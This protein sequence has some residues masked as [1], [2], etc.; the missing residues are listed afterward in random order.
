MATKEKAIKT[1]NRI[2]Y[3]PETDKLQKGILAASSNTLEHRWEAVNII[4][5]LECSPSWQIPTLL[6][7]HI[8]H[9]FNTT[10]ATFHL[11]GELT[12]QQD[13][14]EPIK[15]LKKCQS[16]DFGAQDTKHMPV[17]AEGILYKS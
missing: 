3:M 5:T 9:S 15:M 17:K 2:I 1:P 6:Q 4:R 14:F 8:F 16:E 7:R 13:K 10:L 12:A 11:P